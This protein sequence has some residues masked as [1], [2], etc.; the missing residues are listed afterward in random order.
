[1]KLIKQQL[2]KLFTI[3]VESLLPP[4]AVSRALLKPSTTNIGSK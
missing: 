1:M 4:A 3:A 2:L